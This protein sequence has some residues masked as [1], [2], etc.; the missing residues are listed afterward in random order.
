[1]MALLQSPTVPDELLLHLVLFI[2]LYVSGAGVPIPEEIP[3]AFGGYLVHLDKMS[4]PGLF[5][6]VALAL[7]LGDLTA[8]WLGRRFGMKL[9]KIPPFRW[10]LKPER[11]EVLKQKFREHEGKTIFFGRF[12]AGVRLATFVLAG[13]AHVNV[14]KFAVLDFLA[15]CCTAP[16]PI[17]AAYYLGDPDVARKIAGRID[18]VLGSVVIVGAIC[19]W[20]WSRRQARLAAN[21]PSNPEQGAGS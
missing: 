19:F 14:V 9:A 7:V 21:T 10:V 15:A 12:L 1:M 16:V 6:T 4:F 18:L 13:M 20:I 8:Y 5:V 2:V 11:L 17:L 3:L